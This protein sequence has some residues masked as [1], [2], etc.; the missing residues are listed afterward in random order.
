MTTPAEGKKKWLDAQ[1]CLY[2]SGAA[3]VS[4]GLLFDGPNGLTH[5]LVA[6]GGFCLLIPVLPI[7]QGFV[8]GLR[9]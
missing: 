2:W 6:A 9:R 3:L 1:D 7:V 4:L 8:K 5:G